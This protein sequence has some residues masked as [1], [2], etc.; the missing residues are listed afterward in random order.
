VEADI[1]HEEADR[2]LAAPALGVHAGVGD[3]PRRAVHEALDHAEPADRI[4]GIHAHLVRQLLGIEAPALA[5]SGDAD[6]AV[7]QRNR[8]VLDRDRALP[9]MTGYRLVMGQRRQGPLWPGAGIA[10]VDIISAGARAIEARA[11][12]I[13]ARRAE[14]DRGRDPPDL[15]RRARD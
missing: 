3:E 7:K 14:F 12:R 4:I 11:L 5:I 6:I 8:L 15:H 10:Q 1:L 13:A 9:E 2:L